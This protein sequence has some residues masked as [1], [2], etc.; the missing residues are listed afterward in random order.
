MRRARAAE[1]PIALREEAEREAH[2]YIELALAADRPTLLP[3]ALVIMGGL[4]ASGKSTVSAGLADLMAVPRIVADTTRGALVER[5]TRGV[6]DEA[7]LLRFLDDR[8]GER[9]YAEA[10][11]QADIVLTSGRGAIVDACFPTA[12][13]RQSASALSERHGI[14][15]FFIE[16][17]IDRD[18]ARALGCAGR[19]LVEKRYGVEQTS[20]QLGERP[21]QG[22]ERS[23]GDVPSRRTES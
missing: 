1:T 18:T 12:L 15:L 4:M 6:A 14:P 13:T 11:H 2:R 10:F 17:R 5:E 21:S 22:H 19:T 3:R 8:F 23:S 16:C 7:A 20:P 9:V